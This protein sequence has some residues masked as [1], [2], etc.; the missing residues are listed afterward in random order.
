MTESSASVRQAV[1]LFDGVCNFCNGS[2]R[3]IIKRDPREYFRFAALQSATGRKLLEAHQLPTDALSSMVLIEQGRVFVRSTAALRI[4]R[5]MRFPWPLMYVFMVVP[6][7]LRDWVYN[8]IARN[9]YRVFGR[10][11]ACPIPPAGIASRFL[12]D[13]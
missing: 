5:R 12:G 2:V 1:V 9:R 10:Q 7:F 8:L 11:D 6:G 3:F 13:A 4:A